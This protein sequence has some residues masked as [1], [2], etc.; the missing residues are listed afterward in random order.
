MIDK[1]QPC[2]YN[3]ADWRVTF[4]EKTAALIFRVNPTLEAHAEII[5]NKTFKLRDGFAEFE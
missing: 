3:G 4:M 2:R 5:P 1:S